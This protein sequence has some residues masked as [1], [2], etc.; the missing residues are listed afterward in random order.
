MVVLLHQSHVRLQASYGN[1]TEV[2]VINQKENLKSNFSGF[3]HTRLQKDKLPRSKD[4]LL[5][6]D[7]EITYFMSRT[8]AAISF[9]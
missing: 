2:E 5:G 4:C 1:I 6:P 3:R 9:T 7:S 8:R